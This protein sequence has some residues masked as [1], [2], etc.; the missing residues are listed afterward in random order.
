MTNT[1]TTDR[2]PLQMVAIEH[3]KPEPEQVGHLPRVWCRPCRDEKRTR[4]CSEHALIRC[5]VCSQKITE[6]H[7]HLDY[8]G[9]ADVGRALTMIDAEWN[10]EPCGWTEDGNPAITVRSNKVLV[11]WGRLTLLGVTRICVGSCE[12]DKTEADKELVGDLIRN[13][14]MRHNVY[15]SLWSKSEGISYDDTIDTSGTTEGKG[16]AP[17][18]PQRPT[19]QQR[20]PTRPTLVPPPT[21]EGTP[22]SVDDRR[23]LRALCVDLAE[24]QMLDLRAWCADR[25]IAITLAG[26]LPQSTTVEEIVEIRDYILSMD[27]DTA[28]D[29]TGVAEPGY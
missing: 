23:A 17:K 25:D 9:H 10:W 24:N 13:G 26:Q 29:T 12:I 8:V 16:E 15:G 14:A 28:D 11:M 22:S 20:Q 2:H 1:E 5:D 19:Q 27:D 4:H 6:A 18:Q 7:L 3:W 21:K